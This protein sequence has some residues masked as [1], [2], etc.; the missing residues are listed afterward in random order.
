[1][2]G[3]QYFAPLEWKLMWSK[4]ETKI[5]PKMPPSLHWTYYALAKLGRWHDSKRTGFFWLGSI[6]G[7]MVCTE[8]TARRSKDHATAD[9]INMIKRQILTQGVFFK[10]YRML[11]FISNIFTCW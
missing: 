1:M 5:I 9:E 4:T 2:S 6:M 7:R 10:K 8:S 3:E 11:Y